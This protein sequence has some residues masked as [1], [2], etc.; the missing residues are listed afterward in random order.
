MNKAELLENLNTECANWDA[1]LAEV[2]EGRMMQPGVVGDWSVK[3]VTAHLT[4]WERRPLEW[5]RAAQH[6]GT[7]RPPD[8]S[9]GL[10]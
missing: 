1:L 3:D 8:W 7:P 9:K 10:S 4:T 2:G 6:G 5:L